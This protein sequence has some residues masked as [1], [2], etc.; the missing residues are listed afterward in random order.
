MGRAELK[1]P[2]G[3]LLRAASTV[4]HGRLEEIKITGDFFMHPEEALE[5]LEERLKGIQA[6][7]E[8]IRKTVEK[9]FKIVAPIV[10]G[11]SPQHFIE[12]IMSSAS[13]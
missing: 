11:A 13:A 5:E 8:A 10:L 4:R 7:E 2:G 12:V 9:F 6:D 1:V 3:K